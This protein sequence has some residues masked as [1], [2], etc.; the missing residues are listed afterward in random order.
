VAFTPDAVAAL[1]GYRWP[2]NVRELA[3]VVER[4]TILA[5]GPVTSELVRQVVPSSSRHPGESRGPS[6]TESSRDPGESPGPGSSLTDSL[7]NHER[8]LIQA[9]LQDANGVVAEAARALQTDRANLYR[10]MK[11]LGLG[12]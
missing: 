7:D 4:L 5:E 12:E 6:A 11:R 10:R 2:G 8:A 1:A 9:A 3:N